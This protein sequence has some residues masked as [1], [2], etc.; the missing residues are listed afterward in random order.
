MGGPARDGKWVFRKQRREVAV[1]VDGPLTIAASEVAISAGLDGLDIVVASYPSLKRRL[2]KG[3]LV[4]VLPDWEQDA[5]A[6]HAI[7]PNGQAKPAA[8]A[9]T[10]F[11]VRELV[12]F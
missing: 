9:F 5:I 12:D 11:L 7:Y 10:E 8:G 6:A 3:E 2:E 4:R 1:K